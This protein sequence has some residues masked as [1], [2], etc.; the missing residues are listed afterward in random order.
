MSELVY[1]SWAERDDLHVA[2]EEMHRQLEET[3]AWPIGLVAAGLLRVAGDLN[4]ETV[5]EAAVGFEVLA[6]QEPVEVAVQLL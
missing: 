1:L 4:N 2:G 5:V 3:P 6:V